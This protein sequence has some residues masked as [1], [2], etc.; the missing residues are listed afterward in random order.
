MGVYIY[1][2]CMRVLYANSVKYSFMK[3]VNWEQKG[4]FNRELRFI[5]EWT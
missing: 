5:I 4:N 3:F 1:I 2:Y